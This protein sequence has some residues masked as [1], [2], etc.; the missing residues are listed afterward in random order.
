MFFSPSQ[1]HKRNIM[2]N[3][4]FIRETVTL[5]LLFGMCYGLAVFGYAWGL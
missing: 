5:T 2:S 3:W 4:T 1:E